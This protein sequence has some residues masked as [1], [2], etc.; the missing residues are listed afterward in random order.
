MNRNEFAAR[1]ADFSERPYVD[2]YKIVMAEYDRLTA[3]NAALK[4]AFTLLL[5]TYENATNADMHHHNCPQW[6]RGSGYD[7]YPCTCGANDSMR[8]V[9]AFAATFPPAPEVQS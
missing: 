1:L 5:S 6:V 3:E 9:Y 4:E 7:G 2:E 8:R